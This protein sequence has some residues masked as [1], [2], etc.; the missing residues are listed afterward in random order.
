MTEAHND[1]LLRFFGNNRGKFPFSYILETAGLYEKELKHALFYLVEI[2]RI[3]FE[4]GI[5]PGTN[6]E[7]KLYFRVN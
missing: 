1:A 4:T 5:W 7:Q 3:E 2:G 6:F